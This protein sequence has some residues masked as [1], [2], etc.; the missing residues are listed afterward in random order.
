M[1]M[2]ESYPSV[3]TRA[4]ETMKYV[5]TGGKPEQALVVHVHVADML[6]GQ[7]DEN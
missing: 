4:G 7:G 6:I 1:I 3:E 5:L 2:A